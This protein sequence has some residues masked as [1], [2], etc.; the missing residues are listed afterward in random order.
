MVV[1]VRTCGSS[2]GGYPKAPK[3]TD[4]LAAINADAPTRRER[5]TLE[6][7]LLEATNTEVT[8]A[9]QAGEIDLGKLMRRV[10]KLIMKNGTYGL[11]SV[12]QWLTLP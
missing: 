2:K 3:A 1:C 6:T 9:C 12:E 5:E 7:Y 4:V 8:M 10:E 11:R